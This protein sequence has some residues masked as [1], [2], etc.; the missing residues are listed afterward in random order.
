MISPDSICYFL[1]INGKHIHDDVFDAA[2][3]PNKGSR[4]ILP[5][6]RSVTMKMSTYIVIHVPKLISGH[7]EK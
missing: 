5:T 1:H 6:D 7:Q 3:S 2:V 4:Y